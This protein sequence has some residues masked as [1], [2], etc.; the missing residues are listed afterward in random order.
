M[1]TVFSLSRYWISE[2]LK[3]MI[4][5]M[6]SGVYAS[7]YFAG[8]HDMPKGATRGAARRAMTYS[9]GSISFGSLGKS[10]EILLLFFYLCLTFYSLF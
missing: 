2:F 4:H 3:N 6:I 1:L 9:F 5:V 7:W 10:F 8:D